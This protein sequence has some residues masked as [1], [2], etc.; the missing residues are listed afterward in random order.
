M[1]TMEGGALSQ[2]DA[3]SKESTELSNLNRDSI[4][5][6]VRQYA[7]PMAVSDSMA[8]LSASIS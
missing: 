6:L 3:S 4:K 2:G 5:T 1:S 8:F 7:A